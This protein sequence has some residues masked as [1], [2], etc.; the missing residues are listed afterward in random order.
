MSIAGPASSEDASDSYNHNISSNDH[1]RR[2]LRNG[3]SHI[4]AAFSIES[5]PFSRVIAFRFIRG[6]SCIAL[7][8]NFIDVRFWFDTGP[9]PPFKT[10]PLIPPF[11]HH[12]NSSGKIFLS[13]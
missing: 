4:L 3:I 1:P 13:W 12:H 9:N 6:M 8:L 10:G 2:K 5:K 7:S 11:Q